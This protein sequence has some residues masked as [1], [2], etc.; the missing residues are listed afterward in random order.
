MGESSSEIM[1]AAQVIAAS[2]LALTSAVL[3]LAEVQLGQK[4]YGDKSI[5]AKELYDRALELLRK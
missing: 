4:G 5:E 2:N 3:K 1:T